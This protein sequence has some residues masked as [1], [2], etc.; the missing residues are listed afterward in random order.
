MDKTEKL[1]KIAL[2]YSEAVKELHAI[3]KMEDEKKKEIRQIIQEIKKV[4]KC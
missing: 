1:R 4:M 3:Q 2:E